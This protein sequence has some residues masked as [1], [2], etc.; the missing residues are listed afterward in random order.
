MPA[1]LICH[2]LIGP[3][4]SGKST[5]AAQMSQLIPNSRIISTDQIRGKLYGNEEIQGD[6]AEI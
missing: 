2:Y 6:W 1:R 3:P 5:L 4:G